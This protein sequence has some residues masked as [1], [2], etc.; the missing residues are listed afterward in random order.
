MKTLAIDPGDHQSAYVLLDGYKPVRFSKEDNS[1][2][3]DLLPGLLA[4]CEH[5]AIEMVASYGMPVGASVFETCLW[6]GRYIELARNADRS[7]KLVYRME[8]KMNLCHAAN[9]RDANIRR[10][11]IDRFARHDMKNGKGTKKNPDVFYSFSA[12]VWQAFGLAVTYLDKRKG[13]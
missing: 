7:A 11:L 2:L 1:R 8:V 12:D 9:A 4:E 3:L 13:P 6:I 10:A 5:V